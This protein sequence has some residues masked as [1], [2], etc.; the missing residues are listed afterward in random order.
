MS[1]RGGLAALALLVAAAP[2]QARGEDQPLVRARVEPRVVMVGAPATLTVDVLVPTWMTA[3]PQF[4]EIE[5]RDAVVIFLERDGHNLSERLDGESWAGLRREYRIYPIRPQPFTISG[6]EVVITYAIDARPSRP[7]PVTI[8]AVSFRATVPDE[9]AGLDYFFSASAFNLESSFDRPLKDI[10]VGE[11]VTRTITLTA[12][13]SFSMMLPTLEP[14]S[15]DGIAVY[16]DP[17]V[18]S[19]TG[20][21][22]GEARIAHRTETVSYV[23]R[24]EGRYELPAIDI[25]W[26][27]SHSS[28]LR[29][30]SL[31]GVELEVAANPG[32]AEEIP[33][34]PEEIAA[35]TAGAEVTPRWRESLKRWALPIILVATLAWVAARW[36]RGALPGLRASLDERRRR[37]EESEASYFKRFKKAC[38]TGDPATILRGLMSWLD[39]FTPPPGPATLEDFVEDSRDPELAEQ[40]RLLS[41]AVYT[42]GDGPRTTEQSPSGRAFYRRVARARNGILRRGVVQPSETTTLP[43]L[44]P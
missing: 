21:E 35:E 30:A 23:F 3:A 2:L 31:P 33:L 44:N 37:R 5:I 15:V 14:P 18:L 16:P 17:P 7:T 22:R 42:D 27:D 9:A 11:A 43:A 38:R 34:P 20:G 6:F 10:E 24:E 26:W 1:R 19:D 25:P 29:T 28:R 41:D 13:D 39:R 12:D 8:P 40:A 36:I 4:P 32:L